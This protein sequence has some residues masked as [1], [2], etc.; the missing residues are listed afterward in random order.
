MIMIDLPYCGIAYLARLTFD[1]MILIHSTVAE[2][3]LCRGNPENDPIE[4]VFRSV[5]FRVRLL[6]GYTRC[7]KSQE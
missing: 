4:S 2:Q 1:A 6:T 3:S 7:R 5:L